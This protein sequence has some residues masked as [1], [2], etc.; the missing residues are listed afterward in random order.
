MIFTLNGKRCAEPY[1]HKRYPTTKLLFVSIL[2]TMLEKRRIDNAKNQHEVVS[3]WRVLLLV[4]LF[5]W[6][7]LYSTFTHTLAWEA[8][9]RAHKR[10]SAFCLHTI[11][12]SYVC[13]TNTVNRFNPMT[14]PTHKW[15]L[16]FFLDSL[17]STRFSVVA[18][19]RVSY[20]IIRYF[21]CLVRNCTVKLKDVW[22][23]LITGK[24]SESIAVIE[25]LACLCV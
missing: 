9:D 2:V 6:V 7:Q 24:C 20:I 8:R 25:H 21:S 4:Y 22:I 14:F 5:N 18:S 1:L 19:T 16:P 10:I 11:K 3:D 17:S 13:S 23:V 15:I 12:D